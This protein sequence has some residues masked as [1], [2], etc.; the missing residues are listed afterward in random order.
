MIDF[1][2]ETNVNP[3]LIKKKSKF[4]KF[5]FRWWRW[6][7]LLLI[8]SLCLFEFYPKKVSHGTSSESEPSASAG[9]QGEIAWDSDYIYVCVGANSWDKISFN[10]YDCDD[11]GSGL[12]WPVDTDTEIEFTFYSENELEV[13]E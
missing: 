1:T 2:K 11:D 9:T 7:C 8:L 10:S 6:I 4:Q 13:S 12:C 5:L 3:N